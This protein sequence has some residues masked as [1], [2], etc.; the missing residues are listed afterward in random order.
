MVGPGVVVGLTT[1]DGR[2]GIKQIDFPGNG[3]TD[4]GL[5]AFRTGQTG[6]YTVDPNCTGFMTVNLGTTVGTVTNALVI[7]N[8]GRAVMPSLPRSLRRAAHR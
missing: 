8:G 7:C 5:T 4:L 1:F 3:G 2:G 6:R